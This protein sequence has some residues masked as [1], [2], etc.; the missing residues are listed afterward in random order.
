MLQISASILAANHAF[1]GRDVVQC[2]NQ[3]VDFIHVDITDGHYTDNLSFGPKL[4]SDLKKI[5]SLPLDVHLG[6]YNQDKFVQKFIDSGADIINLQYETCTRPLHLISKIKE[7][8]KKVS[9]TI[10][11]ATSFEE[12]KILL[13]YLDQINL[14]AVEPGFGGQKLQEGIL[15]KLRLIRDYTEEKN[16]RLK[17]SVD[18]GLNE[19]TIP[20]VAE[21]GADILVIGS[22]VFKND[23][24]EKNIMNIR[25]ILNG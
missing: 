15:E 19:E 13:E 2:E 16:Y 4:I 12:I 23:S 17:I 10:G 11:P 6:I 25:K 24:I 9:M 22:S 18:G 5:T 1:I 20:R 14:L 8:G 21:N 3:S 7:N